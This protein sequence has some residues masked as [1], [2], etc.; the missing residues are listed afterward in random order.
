MDGFADAPFRDARYAPRALDVE[1]RPDGGLVLTN[2]T[3]FSRRFET[4]LA[5]LDHWAVAAPD[6]I[7]L[8]ERDGEGWRAVTYGDAA[9]QVAALA[10][11]LKGLGLGPGRPLMILARNGVDHALI[12]YA[13]MSLAA[14]A[15]PVS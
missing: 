14:P 12:A 3:P 15:A 4:M 6:R 13:A 2:P 8:A 1:R 9:R 7:W 10:G 11:G 5:P